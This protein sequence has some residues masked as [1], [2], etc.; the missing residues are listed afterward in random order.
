VSACV[1]QEQ[2]AAQE[3]LQAAFDSTSSERAALEAEAGSLRGRLAELVGVQQQ[4]AELE[5]TH[6]AA[7]QRLT[8]LEEEHEVLT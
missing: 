3:A 6:D 5:V 1:V 4:L 8:Q 2:T 7:T